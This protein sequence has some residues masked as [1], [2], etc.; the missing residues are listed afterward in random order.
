MCAHSGFF[1]LVYHYGARRHESKQISDTVRVHFAFQRVVS[2]FLGKQRRE[3]HNEI[4]IKVCANSLLF[5]NLQWIDSLSSTRWYLFCGNINCGVHSSNRFLF[6]LLSLVY[7]DI[8]AAWQ[9]TCHISNWQFCFS[10]VNLNKHISLFNLIKNKKKQRKK[11]AKK[12]TS[13]SA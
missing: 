5:K 2:V 11:I 10:A 3:S 8:H 4:A 9:V 13:S 6:K 1:P 12:T 7:T